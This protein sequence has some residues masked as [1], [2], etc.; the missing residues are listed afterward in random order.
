ME[1]FSLE[2]ST[3][4][5]EVGCPWA[6]HLRVPGAHRRDI[7]DFLCLSAFFVAAV[8]RSGMYKH[9]YRQ[10]SA[11]KRELLVSLCIMCP[12]IRDARE[13]SVSAVIPE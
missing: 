3:G 5:E 11:L 9:I 1:L 12:G 4:V 10:A 6:A 13:I 8:L 7:W 2:Q